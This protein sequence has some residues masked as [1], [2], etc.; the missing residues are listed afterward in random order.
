MKPQ[1]V[2]IPVLL[3]LTA[4]LV[5]NMNPVPE[6][7]A[8]T[9]EEKQALRFTE[10][11]LRR[12]TGCDADLATCSFSRKQLPGNPEQGKADAGV[13]QVLVEG[14][15]YDDRTFRCCVLLDPAAQHVEME[16]AEISGRQVFPRFVP[17]FQ[18]S[19]DDL[20]EST[21]GKT[22]LIA[23]AGRRMF[24]GGPVQ[25]RAQPSKLRDST[26]ML[27]NVFTNTSILF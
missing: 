19:P 6:S 9:V 15:L 24:P 17:H 22:P 26:T 3:T 27:M 2:V 1:L 11:F 16:R 10:N 7:P 18:G 5:I 14:S 13:T 12:F 23:P 4:A 8:K 21:D 20:I 25:S